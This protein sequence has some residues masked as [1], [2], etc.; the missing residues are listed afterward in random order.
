MDR[1]IKEYLLNYMSAYVD[2]A[3]ERLEL[4]IETLPIKSF[5]K[6]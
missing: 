6:G 5:K 2:M 3:P 1:N 4:F